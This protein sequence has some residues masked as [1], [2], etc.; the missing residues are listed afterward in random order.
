MTVLGRR[1]IEHE[2]KIP[3]RLD[4]HGVSFRNLDLNAADLE[5]LTY[6][7]RPF[8]IRTLKMHA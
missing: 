8:R 4:L 2:R 7:D 3:G 6:K 1:D 5:E